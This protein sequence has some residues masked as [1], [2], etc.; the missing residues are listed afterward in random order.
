MVNTTIHMIIDL[1][2]KGE[3]LP[4]TIE[5]TKW[6]QEFIGGSMGKNSKGLIIEQVLNPLIKWAYIIVALCL[7]PTG[8]ASDVKLKMLKSI[9]EMTKL[10]KIYN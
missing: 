4:K 2:Y 8:R 7:T 5:I 3:N 10:G 1:P 6:I 9:G